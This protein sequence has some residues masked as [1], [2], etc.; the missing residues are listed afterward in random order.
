MIGRVYA[1]LGDCGGVSADAAVRMDCR[2]VPA[3]SSG[4]C[5]AGIC[6][7]T[8]AALGRPGRPE[9]RGVPAVLYGV[10]V[11]AVPSLTASGV[12]PSCSQFQNP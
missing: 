1:P 7:V 3:G 2:V 11:P 10:W 4:G 9:R 6:L 12:P 5:G 8:P